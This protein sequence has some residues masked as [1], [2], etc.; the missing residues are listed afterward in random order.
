MLTAPSE[1][2]AWETAWTG[3]KRAIHLG[4]VADFD[5]QFPVGGP[6]PRPRPSRWRYGHHYAS[7][8]PFYTPHPAV[9]V[10]P[11]HLDEAW[12]R[13]IA[14]HLQWDSIELHSG[15]ADD[16]TGFADALAARPA[17]LDRIRGA[18]LPMV[19]WGRTPKLDRL[20][21]ATDDGVLA[22]VQRFESKAHAVALFRELMP[23][24]PGIHVRSQQRAQSRRDLAR[25]VSTATGAGRPVVLKSEFGVG[26]VGTVIVTPPDVAAAG[27]ARALLRRLAAEE[28]LLPG[29]DVLVEPYIKPAGRLGDLTFDA[30]VAAD[31]GVHPVGA[32][33]M[34]VEGT[35]YRGATVGPGVMPD[36]V[37]ARLA[38]FGTEVGKALAGHGYRGW[39]DVDFIRDSS[40]RIEPAETNLRLTGPAVA[41]MIKARL[42]RV[43]GP[44]HLVRVLDELPLGARLPEEAVFEHVG[45]LARLCAVLDVLVLPTLP[46]TAFEP[47]PTLG[48]AIA[49]R[50][51]TVLDAAESLV[52]AANAE[53]AGMFDHLAPA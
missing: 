6:E 17:L 12:P 24:C 25:L 15:I 16:D 31:G 45:R 8:A 33:V 20:L 7:L 34:Q 36:E 42:D 1:V 40:G 30:V 22:A 27:G 37:A 53:L 19:P 35:H 43:R 48:L 39:F 18:G 10:L 32:A 2:P 29:N 11:H 47:E 5:A 14:H 26:G 23:A 51:L 41:F 4:N 52:R 46:G 13:L 49:A 50:S 3:G 38:R 21:R 9:V 44:G 28:R